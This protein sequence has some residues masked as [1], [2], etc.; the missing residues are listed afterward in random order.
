MGDGEWSGGL[1]VAKWRVGLGASYP[2]E[3]CLRC[4]LLGLVES[5]LNVA[6]LDQLLAASAFR[7]TVGGLA[8][9]VLEDGH[10]AEL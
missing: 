2:D 9:R 3:R 8:Q 7:K 10:G 4:L 5:D 1:S 6:F